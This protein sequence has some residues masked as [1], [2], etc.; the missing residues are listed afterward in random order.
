MAWKESYILDAYLDLYQYTNERKYLEKFE[1][2]A[3]SI[4]DIIKTQTKRRLISSRYSK[5][6]IKND[7][8]ENNEDFSKNFT[9]VEQIKTPIFTDCDDNILINFG[10]KTLKFKENT[11]L[12]LP[13]V[14]SSNELLYRLRFWIKAPVDSWIKVLIDNTLLSEFKIDSSEWDVF[15]SDFKIDQSFNN[16]H[17]LIIECPNETLIDLV[18]IKAYKEYPVHYGMM[19]KTLLRGLMLGARID[20]NIVQNWLDEM[21]ETYYDPALKFYIF[22]LWEF[23]KQKGQTAFNFAATLGTA[24]IYASQFFKNAN[25]KQIATNVATGFKNT[26]TVKDN[27]IIWPSSGYFKNGV[28][29]PAYARKFEDISHGNIDIDFM[30][31]AYENNIVFT[32]K[33]MLNLADVFINNLW[34][35]DM[36]NPL[37]YKFVDGSGGICDFSNYSGVIWNW[38]E[39]SRFNANIKDIAEK[40]YIK[41]WNKNK[42][43]VDKYGTHRRHL[44]GLTKTLLMSKILEEHK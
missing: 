31:R 39:L 16:Q 22:N 17:V 21:N 3:N 43:L 6:L 13:F 8:F 44:V 18:A 27:T 33:D 14:A 26:I 35:G 1:E 30:I 34:N 29:T 28:L 19:L 37:F 40:F 7:S 24:N 2:R 12:L 42:C 5:N 15:V 20:K 11:Q 25:Y 4:L 10:S 41:Q 38:I 32:K 36:E 9:I 23:D